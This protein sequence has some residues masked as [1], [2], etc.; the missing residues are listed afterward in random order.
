M[1]GAVTAKSNADM[2]MGMIVNEMKQD[3]PE[4]YGRARLALDFMW[5]PQLFLDEEITKNQDQVSG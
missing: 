2:L 5:P 3:V 4:E 1:M